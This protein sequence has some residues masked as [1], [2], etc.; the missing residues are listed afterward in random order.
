MKGLEKFIEPADAEVPKELWK[1]A[2][3]AIATSVPE[4]IH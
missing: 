2:F 1:Y 4:V 3:S